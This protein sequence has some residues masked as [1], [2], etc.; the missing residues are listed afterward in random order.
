MSYSS[1]GTAKWQLLTFG[2]AAQES[3]YCMVMAIIVKDFQCVM[4]DL[5]VV[6]NISYGYLCS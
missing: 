1:Q 6:T 3:F 2:S 4:V 5:N